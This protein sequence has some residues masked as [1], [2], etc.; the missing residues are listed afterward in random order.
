MFPARCI[1]VFA[2]LLALAAPPLAAQ[3]ER[4]F[5]ATAQGQQAVLGVEIQ[6][7]A[8]GL[9]VVTVA[10]GSVAEAAQIQPGDLIV[11]CMGRP[12][13]DG[14]VFQKEVAL[15]HLRGVPYGLEVERGGTRQ[16]IQVQ[17]AGGRIQRRFPGVVTDGASPSPASPV[18]PMVTAPLPGRGFNVLRYAALD[19]AS[20]EVVLW[21]DY[22]PAYATGPLPY[23]ALLA[24]AVRNPAPSFTLEPTAE[25][26]DAGR[27]LDQ[28]IAADSQ[29]MGQDPA[30]A[31]SFGERLVRVLGVDL[32]HRPDG[33]RFARQCARAFGLSSAEAMDLL[34]PQRAQQ[35]RGQN[36]YMAMVAKALR[37]LGAPGVSQAIES[38]IQG[39]T[40]GAIDRLGVGDAARQA[41]SDFQSGRLSE[42]QASN[43]LQSLIWGAFLTNMGVS[44]SFVEGER[45]RRGEAAFVPWAQEQFTTWLASKVMKTMF[46]GMVLGE[47]ALMRLYPRV[48]PVVVE[49][50]CLDGLDPRSELAQAFYRGDVA[51]KS[52][53]STPD[54][55]D[56]VTGHVA[57]AQAMHE[58]MARRGYAD[59]NASVR[60]RTWLRPGAVALSV[61]PGGRVVRFGEARVEVRTQMLADPGNLGRV[62]QEG[63]DA[64]TSG[65]TARYDAY[66]RHLPD[67]HR[68]REAAKVLALARWA[69][70]R[71]AALR[72]EPGA[73]QVLPAT[74]PVGFLQA[75]FLVE[76]ERF[77][78]QPASIGGVDFGPQAGEG[79][80]QA[81]PDAQVVPSAL[82]QLQASAALAGQA[83]D[84][85]LAGD[86]EGA[87]EL[88]Q[89]SADA[90]T[91]RLQGGL[92]PLPAAAGSADP[93]PLAQAGAGLLERVQTATAALKA[94]GPEAE[95]ARADLAGL[96][97]QAQ[98]VAQRPS[99]APKVVA[100][101]RNPGPM[102][103]GPVAAPP[104]A[105]PQPAPPVAAPGSALSPEEQKKLRAEVA[106]LR[107]ELCFIRA[108]M[109]RFNATIQMDQGQRAQWESEV[110]QAQERSFDRLKEMLV[111]LPSDLLDSRWKDAVGKGLRTPEERARLSKALELL[112]HFQQVGTFGEFV[113]W[114]S[115]EDTG[116]ERVREGLTQIYDILD[117]EE[118]LRKMLR[119]W[120]GRPI[121]KGAGNLYDAGKNLVDTGFDLL[122][123]G[124]AWARLR[125][126]NRNAPLFLKAVKAMGDRQRQVLEGIHAREL[127]LGLPPGATREPCE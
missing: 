10:P 49:P 43:R 46:H 8:G 36:G 83:A 45:A 90:M 38:M 126:L 7:E 26:R 104:V 123:E 63:L 6:A 17:P 14:V 92:P 28:L 105:D 68:L 32:A 9:R 1:P 23:R 44:A 22:D 106:A 70:G 24:E 107:Q 35:T 73:P 74:A 111:D 79:W 94:A 48:R 93:L 61:D 69:R 21:G 55:A 103:A 85:A 89:R 3:R 54:L 18:A 56:R 33:Q 119:R 86:L 88:A 72:V 41:R 37:H 65:I 75:T 52:I 64:Y 81:R 87:R 101:L 77:F 11:A 116:A 42:A 100:L 57:Q 59:Q 39:D 110:Q 16:S 13:T 71:G 27:A 127:K 124:F 4:R 62:F 80:V 91:G 125:D 40:W 58:F 47:E 112:G 15:A 109:V 50:R 19:P 82:G 25:G 98:Q 67:L 113:D 51:L 31:Q 115:Q 53:L 76:G 30:Y 20:G 118:V 99:E 2:T 84:R 97:E 96:R 122:A 114:A 78:W 102:P 121:P 60:G 117:G 34:Q 108:R 66:A 95:T 29:R 12:V 120:L 5:P